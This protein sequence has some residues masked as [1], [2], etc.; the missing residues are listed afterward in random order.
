[1]KLQYMIVIFIAVVLPIS[2]VLSVYTQLQIKTMVSQVSY[3]TKLTDATHDAAV[4]LHTNIMNNGSQ[5]TIYDV[6]RANVLAA[7]NV[8]MNSIAT[9][10]GVGGYS[11]NELN[12]HIPAIVYTMY[13]GYYIYTPYSEFKS[14]E[15][16]RTLKPYVYYTKRYTD[17]NTDIVVNYS[18][19]NYIA[20]YGKINGEGVAKSGYLVNPDVTSD[21]GSTYKGYNILKEDGSMESGIFARQKLEQK[22]DRSKTPHEYSYQLEYTLPYKKAEEEKAEAAAEGKTLTEE[23]TEQGKY[24]YAAINYYKE[25]KEFTNFVITN[26]GNFD[27]NGDGKKIFQ[28]DSNNDPEDEGSAFNAERAKVIKDSIEDNLIIAISNFNQKTPGTSNYRIPEMSS[29]DWD[30]V[31]KD[32]TVIAYMEGLKS[33]FKTYNSYAI[34]PLASNNLY[35]NKND[36]Y[37][38]GNDPN[39]KY[40]HTLNCNKIQ[41]DKITGYA[42]YNFTKVGQDVSENSKIVTKYF[43]LKDFLACYHCAVNRTMEPVTDDAMK[44]KYLTAYYT[45]IARERQLTYKTS[46]M[47]TQTTKNTTLN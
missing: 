46:N 5:A 14:Q 13:D 7:T 27:F 20:I 21:D 39:E 32:F 47:I 34:T 9:S 17:G 2:L 4:A 31:T 29:T 16:K 3:D 19:D 35:V 23:E 25:A 28:I 26:L 24:E 11:E 42:G 41:G 37:Y 33:G 8:F 6:M 44:N 12:Q 45:A 1:M 40:Y 43:Y 15:E 30:I 38:K 10:L 18:L 22:E 36:I